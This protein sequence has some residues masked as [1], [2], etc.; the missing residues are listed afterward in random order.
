MKE[1]IPPCFSVDEIHKSI[2]KNSP[3]WYL[4][5]WVAWTILPPK[6]SVAGIAWLLGVEDDAL[7]KTARRLQWGS[8]REMRTAARESSAKE[9]KVPLPAPIRK[10]NDIIFSGE[11][12]RVSLIRLIKWVEYKAKEAA[13]DLQD[14]S[15]MNGWLVSLAGIDAAIRARKNRHIERV[16]KDSVRIY[17][18]KMDPAPEMDIEE[19]KPIPQPVEF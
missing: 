15:K 4:R 18:P 11:I 13:V 10:G 1:K 6:A 16:K 19:L 3:D 9:K 12:P 14:S 5:A 8:R 7:E 2:T 17:L